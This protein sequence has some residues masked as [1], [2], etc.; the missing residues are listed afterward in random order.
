MENNTG[1]FINLQIIVTMKSIDGVNMQPFILHIFN[2]EVNHLNMVIKFLV[3]YCQDPQII[4]QYLQNNQDKNIIFR[5]DLFLLVIWMAK[6]GCCKR[7]IITSHILKKKETFPPIKQFPL[8]TPESIITA[9]KK[10]THL[11]KK[12]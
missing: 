10:V 3:V 8:K 12:F 11:H 9:N 7:V 2:M 1:H 4:F 5:T 6:T